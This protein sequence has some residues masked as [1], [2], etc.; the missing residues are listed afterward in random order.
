MDYGLFLFGAEDVAATDS[1]A[2]Q[3]GQYLPLWWGVVSLLLA[4]TVPTWAV[5][6]TEGEH[7]GRAQFIVTTDTATWFY[8]KAGGGV[9][10]LIDRN[11]RDWVAFSKTPLNQ[12]PESAAAG[13]RGLGNLVYGRDNQDAGAG[14]PGFDQCDSELV[15][16]RTIRS[17]SRSGR[18]AWTWTFFPDRAE[19]VMEQADPDRSW[20]FLYEGP[21]AGTFNPAAQFCGTSAGGPYRDIP[22][23]RNQRFGQWQWAYFGDNTVPRVLLLVQ[24]TPDELDDTFWY[25]G[26]SRGGAADALDGMV[27]FGFGRGPGTRPLFHG[28]GQRISVGFLETEQPLASH[29]VV[30]RTV[31]GA[32]KGR[33]LTPPQPPALTLWHGDRQRFGHRGEPQRWIN[34]LGKV[35]PV[36]QVEVLTG[37]LNGGAARALSLGTDL[38]RLA[39]PGDFNVELAW[40]DLKAGTNW[41]TLKATFH[42]G[43][44]V[45]TNVQVLVERGRQW[46]L[47]YRVDFATVT[48]LQDVVQVVDGLWRLTADGVR[49][50][51]PYYDRVLVLGDRSWTNYEAQVRL[52]IHGFTPPQRGP[53]TYNVTHFGMALRWRGHT[54]DGRQPSRQWYP[55][56]AQG[57]LLLRTDTES[58]R[59]RVLPGPDSGLSVTLAAEPSA[60]PLEQPIYVRAQ[61][62]TLADGRSRYRF[63]HWPAGAP[64]PAAWSVEAFKPSEKDFPSGS[65]GLVAHNADVTLHEIAV[66]PLPG[67]ETVGKTP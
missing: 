10:R 43:H 67:P 59:W 8:D 58:C 24:H 1:T 20:W 46:L 32:L 62:Q 63:Q 15:D 57:E 42:D 55:L 3:V 35:E 2:A 34:L 11:G 26:S 36:G 61:V 53:P 9:S 23:I 40:D 49:T 56:G 60:I 5:R 47:P 38:H 12:F 65:L 27:V 64:K 13:F 6:I 50:V 4:L 25:L 7:E 29:V 45:T 52:T 28:A 19:F 41:L 48:N 54:T 22:D 30:E 14:H 39:A 31:T 33:P 44:I 16:A 37:S 17:R 66:H 21:V 51:H 18:W